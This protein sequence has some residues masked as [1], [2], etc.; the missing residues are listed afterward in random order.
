M[1]TRV[2]VLA[3]IA[4]LTCGCSAE[5]PAT[6]LERLIEE[7]EVEAESRN[8][9]HFRALVADS[10]VDARGNDRDQLINLIRGYFLAHQSIDV[11]TRIESVDLQGDDAAQI[12]VLAGVLAR[13]PGEGLLEGLD[14]R[15]YR[16]ELELVDSGG[17]W[18]IIGADWERSLEVLRGD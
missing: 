18:Q 11:I 12:I 16:L 6:A 4:V 14:G 10:Y 7:A 1:P 17:D 2:S 5:D 3:V 9:G 15:L 13:R 8:T